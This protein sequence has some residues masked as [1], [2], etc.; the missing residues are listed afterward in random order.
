MRVRIDSQRCQG[1]VRCY[2]TVPEIIDVD[3]QGHGTVRT[4]D[5]PPELEEKVHLSVGGCPE[6]AILIEGDG[7]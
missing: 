5:I 2:A 7:Q 1:H 3:E 4:A 6:R